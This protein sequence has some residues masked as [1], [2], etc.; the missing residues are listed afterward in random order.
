MKKLEEVNPFKSTVVKTDFGTITTL[1][2]ESGISE[3]GSISF[4]SKTLLANYVYA[5]NETY[6]LVYT[7]VDKEGKHE[8]FAENDGILP[9]LF[10]SPEN[11]AYVSVVPYDPDKELEISIP[12]FNRESIDLPKGSRPFV[13]KFIGTTKL[14]SIFYDVDLWS[15]T[16]PD[17]LLA[18]EFKNGA[19]K[20]KHNVKISLPRNNKIFIADNEIHLLANDGKSWLHRQI[21]EKGNVVR[22]RKIQP[23]KNCFSE[24]FNLSFNENSYIWCAKGG[25]ISLEIVSPNGKCESKKLADIGGE[26]YNTW[27]PVKISAD[28]YVATFNGDLGNGWFTIKNDQI[29]ELFYSKGEKGYKNL[30]TNEVLQMNNENLCISSV[31]KTV[32]NGYAVVFYPMT[33]R[34]IKNK[35]LIILNREITMM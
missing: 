12:V 20:K 15:D 28:T 18:V 30:L 2:T 21:D 7:V 4:E 14:F 32:E 34:G 11:E 22:E 33:E 6:K 8:S 1:L 31:N 23:T 27:K 13:G 10:L 26:F 16:K 3:H 25:E 29:L 35:E 17:K 24:I 19:I 9:M 5:K